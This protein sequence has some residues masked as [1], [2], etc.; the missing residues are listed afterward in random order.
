MDPDE[1]GTAL[2]RA[3]QDGQGMYTAAD[4]LG[5]A[6]Q[7]RMS[8][9]VR[10]GGD[11]AQEVAKFL[12]QRQ[13]DQPER[14][15]S[16]VSDAYDGSKTAAATRAGLTEARDTAAGINYGA[17]RAGAGPVNLTPTIETIDDLLNVNPILGETALA[18][19]DI[20]QR[21]QALRGRMQ[22]GGEQLIDFNEVLTLKQELGGQIENLRNTGKRVPPQLAAVYKSLD[23]ALEASSDGYRLANDSFRD[24]SRTIEA[25][26]EGAAM[27]SPRARAADTTAQFSAMTPEQ[28][29]AARVGYGDQALARVEASAGE[30]TN[31]ARPFTSTKIRTEAPVIANNSDLFLRRMDRENT[32]HGTLGRALGGSRTADNLEDIADIQGFDSG[33][34]VN[35]LTGQ[36]RAAVQQGLQRSGNAL[37][38]MTPETRRIVAQALMARDETAFRKALQQAQTSDARKEVV[39]AIL[40]VAAQREEYGGLVQP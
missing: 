16:F 39:D 1:L 31:R 5:Q 40:R 3:A 13:L 21:I 9:I 17:A 32:M 28:Q 15:A 38:G 24:A 30:M 27:F 22:A 36:W 8:G 2:M 23:A 29:A 10:S 4:A 18:R 26:D 19:S 33:P 14:V 35:L 34:L 37:T 7:R 12:Q 25:V 6:G 11:A 20:G